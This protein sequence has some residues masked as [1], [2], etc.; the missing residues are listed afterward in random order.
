MIFQARNVH[1]SASLFNMET[2]NLLSFLFTSHCRN[3]Y[4]INTPALSVI[5]PCSFTING[6][7]LV[8]L[9]EVLNGTT[10]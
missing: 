5:Y 10:F 8:G 9:V 7:I 4:A 1:V 3:K 2:V 6:I